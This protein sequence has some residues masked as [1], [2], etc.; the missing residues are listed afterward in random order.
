VN[1]QV[2]LMNLK[3]EM[4]LLKRE[5]AVLTQRVSDIENRLAVNEKKVEDIEVSGSEHEVKL[6]LVENAIETITTNQR[7][8]FLPHF[9]ISA[10]LL[11]FVY[12]LLL[13]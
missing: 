5:G 11:A 1:E 4:Q 2:D 6:R 10:L 3:Q 13:L 9:I 7:S 12:V 8:A